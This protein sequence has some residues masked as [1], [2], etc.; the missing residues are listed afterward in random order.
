MI[1]QL[2]G[3]VVAAMLTCLL[4][5]CAAVYCMRAAAS[6]YR[7]LCMLHELHVAHALSYCLVACMPYRWKMGHTDLMAAAYTLDPEF[8]KHQHMEGDEVAKGMEDLLGKLVTDPDVY[9]RALK[10]LND[11]QNRQGDF[12]ATTTHGKAMWASAGSMPAWEWWQT[13]A[14]KAPELRHVAMR[15]L[16]CT[17]TSSSC[18]RNWSTDEFIHSKKRNKLT[19]QRC[20]DLVYVFTN[21]RLL[22]RAAQ[23]AEKG[24]GHDNIAWVAQWMDSDE[25]SSQISAAHSDAQ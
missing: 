22:R 18:E 21:R 5:R 25:E 6:A 19:S 12:S 7:T 8:I 3:D 15:V 13:Y 2:P 4:N 23:R 11:Y 14:K 17:V 16:A 9:G 1:P 20:S 24:V 10:Q